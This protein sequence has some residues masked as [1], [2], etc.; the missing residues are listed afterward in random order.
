MLTDR[1][2]TPWDELVGFVPRNIAREALKADNKADLQLTAG[3]RSAIVEVKLGHLMSAD[4]QAAYESIKTSPDLY[5]AALKADA[6]SLPS[7]TDRWGFLS[8]SDLIGA[9]EHSGDDLARL[10]SSEAARV[11]R[12]WD[13]QITGVLSDR[14]SGAGE[15]MST[16][17]QKFLARV[18][19]RRMAKELR[20]RGRTTWAGVLKGGGL[21]IVQSW[22]PIRDESPDRSFIAEI[23][24]WDSKPGGELRFGIDF[25]PRPGSD[26]DEEVRRAAYDLAHSMDD[27]ID[28]AGLKAQLTKNNPELAQLL[29]RDKPCRPK[30]KGHWEQVIVHGFHGARLPDGSVN[31]RRK[32]KPDFYGDGT[33]R[34]EAIANIDFG[35]ASAVDLIELIDATLC[36]LRTRQP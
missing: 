12:S 22:T 11:L 23:R 31:N 15:P 17:T 8:L 2:S 4:Q 16:L 33:L 27:A 1:D 7:N 3:A 35:R 6:A 21:A 20:N 13:T 19:T 5:L 9:W 10:L 28:Y 26:E 34:H 32:T 18:V 25:S 30:A 29:H 36:Y 14:S 24:W